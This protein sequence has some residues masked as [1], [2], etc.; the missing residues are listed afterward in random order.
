MAG[1][2]PNEGASQF[3]SPMSPS[4][5]KSF[6]TFP[7]TCAKLTE[8]SSWDNVSAKINL[9]QNENRR[10]NLRISACSDYSCI[11]RIPTPLRPCF[12][13]GDLRR[14]RQYRAH[15]HSME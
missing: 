8:T 12:P 13:A 14:F 11:L 5:L 7:I 3:H 1:Y 10:S 2:R 6:G 15:P 4:S 9:E